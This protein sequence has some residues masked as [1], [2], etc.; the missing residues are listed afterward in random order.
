MGCEVLHEDRKRVLI[1]V[2]TEHGSKVIQFHSTCEVYCFAQREAKDLCEADPA[3]FQTCF[4]SCTSDLMQRKMSSSVIV[5][6]DL[7]PFK[8]LLNEVSVK[9]SN[10]A[11]NNLK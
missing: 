1:I 4:N 9:I 3:L 5:P 7:L 2:A 11:R 8:S 6:R 10:E